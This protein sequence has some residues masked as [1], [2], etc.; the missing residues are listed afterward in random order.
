MIKP[1]VSEQ[2]KLDQH[3]GEGHGKD[4]KPWIRV[5]EFN[6]LGTTSNPVDWKNGRT[7]QL[8]SQGEMYAYYIN[9]WDESVIDIREQFP[10]DLEDTLRIADSEHLKHPKNRESRMTSDLLLDYADGSQKVLSIKYDRSALENDRT[11]VK[12]WIEKKYWEE[13]GVPFE[14]QY[15]AEMNLI[16]VTNIRMVTEFYKGEDVFDSVSYLKYLIANHSIEVDMEKSLIPFG[17]LVKDLG[18]SWEAGGVC[19]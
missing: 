10:L 18:I 13:K 15:T 16:L 12:L 7:M 11:A 3:R 9:R 6:S 19:K 8:L 1:K 17:K 14:I 2:T 4:Y 5:N